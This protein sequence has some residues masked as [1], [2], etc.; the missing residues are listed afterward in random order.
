MLRLSII[1]SLFILLSFSALF[2]S[3]TNYKNEMVQKR[4]RF[5][6]TIK[7]NGNNFAL[8]IF[9]HPIHFKNSQGKWE[10]IDP[11]FISFQNGY[12]NFKNTFR[13][14]VN[15]ERI[16]LKD[17]I[18][19]TLKEFSIITNRNR[20]N[21]SLTP[22]KKSPNKIILNEDHSF[23]LK[24]SYGKL[25]LSID[26]AGAQKFS[27][28]ITNDGNSKVEK[29]GNRI[30]IKTGTGEIGYI[31]NVPV[32]RD[33]NNKAFDPRTMFIFNSKYASRRQK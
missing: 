31:L 10:T 32:I 11:D 5:S 19:L 17:A 4:T 15:S 8:A 6:K 2:P 26:I 1:L 7:Q 20:L 12:A 24:S 13:S 23:S 14:I 22:N 29:I 27:F 25:Q 28:I 18:T 33:K 30:L 3:S 9:N 21:V 16:K